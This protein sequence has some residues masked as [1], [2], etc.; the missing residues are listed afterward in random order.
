MGRI[1]TAAEAKREMETCVK[2]KERRGTCRECCSRYLCEMCHIGCR[3][4]NETICTT[5]RG[6]DGSFMSL[7]LKPETKEVKEEIC[8]S[9]EE[10]VELMGIMYSTATRV[11][12]KTFQEELDRR[13]MHSP[14]MVEF[15]KN[16]VEGDLSHCYVYG[17]PL[18][19]MS[20]VWARVH[21]SAIYIPCDRQKIG[22]HSYVVV[23]RAL[24]K[25]VIERYQ[26]VFVSRPNE[27]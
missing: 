11:S 8:N 7:I 20:S 23:P 12:P 3:G 18:R 2:C 15:L 25:E 22:Y 6:E 16:N 17:S 26:L 21:E 24:D 19:P 1:L 14:G 27:G 5:K 9:W 10:L 13:A 4:K